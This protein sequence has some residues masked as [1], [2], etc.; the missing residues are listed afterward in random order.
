MD[1]FTLENDAKAQFARVCLNI[2]ITKPVPRSIKLFYEN[3]VSEFFLSYEG[4]Y[5]AC[6]V[7]GGKD[8]TLNAFPLKP[9]LCLELVVAKLE[10]NHLDP[11]PLFC[12]GV[13][14]NLRALLSLRLEPLMLLSLILLTRLEVPLR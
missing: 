7:C 4:V 3:E 12:P 5:E 1:K 2:D 13:G 8:H 6:P 9:A 11:G 14:E 10:A